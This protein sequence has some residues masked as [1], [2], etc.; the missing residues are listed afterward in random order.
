[1]KLVLALALLGVIL[2]ALVVLE[3]YLELQQRKLRRERLERQQEQR[4]QLLF[5]REDRSYLSYNGVTPGVLDQ[6]EKE[7]GNR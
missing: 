4:R 3:T 6:I 7:I 2:I 5:T 1:M